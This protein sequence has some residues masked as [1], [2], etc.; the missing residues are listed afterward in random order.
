MVGNPGVLFLGVAY[1]HLGAHGPSP[2]GNYRADVSAAHD[3]ELHLR[4]FESEPEQRCPDILSH[5]GSIASRGIEHIDT[6]GLA[7]WNIDLVRAY[8]GRG[9]RLDGGAFEQVSVATRSRAD[10]QSVGIFYIFRGEPELVDI[11]CIGHRFESAG[12]IWNIVIDNYFHISGIRGTLCQYT[13][14]SPFSMRTNE[15]T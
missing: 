8:C 15:A 4:R 7:P 14:L 13:A 6:G 9:D 10:H 5:G 12:Y 3:T 2:I 1:E 11:N